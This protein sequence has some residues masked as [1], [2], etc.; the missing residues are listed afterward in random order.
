MAN[1]SVTYDNRNIYIDF[2]DYWSGSGQ[3][4]AQQR[5]PNKYVRYSR[6]QLVLSSYDPRQDFIKAR[7]EF[8]FPDVWQLTHPHVSLEAFVIDSVNGVT[9]TDNLHLY[10]LIKLI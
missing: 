1:V 8:E 5:I 10:N 3:P 6:E 7:I 2:G 9:P 4:Q